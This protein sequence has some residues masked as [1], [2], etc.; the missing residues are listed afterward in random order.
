MIVRT[1]Q[2][3]LEQLKNKDSPANSPAFANAVM[4]VEPANFSVSAE[5]AVDNHYMNLDDGVDA[6]LALRQSCDLAALLAAKGIEVVSF[7][8]DPNTPDAIFPNNVFASTSDHLI[9][10][11]MLHPGRQAEAEREDIRSYFQ[12]RDYGTIDLSQ[13]DCVAE[14][15]GVLNID[16]ARQIGFCGLTGRVDEAGLAAM[17][18]AFD[19]KMTFSFELQPEEYHSNV[20]MMVLASSACVI[21]PDAFVDKLVPEAIE[22][23]FPER[24]LLLSKAEK[25]AFAGNCIALTDSDLFMSQTGIDALRPASRDALESWGFTIHGTR[26]DEIEK[27]GGS[28]RCMLAEIF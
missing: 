20:I 9:I 15:T 27:A 12:S 6:Q 18:D 3:F 5:S 2:E 19:L 4:M 21:H 26:L 25:N 28:L 10:G 16:H 14:L 22:E 8:G 23:A 11:H 13:S 1:P 24:T 7:P 17:D